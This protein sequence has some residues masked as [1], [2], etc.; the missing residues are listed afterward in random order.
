M[1]PKSRFASA[2][3]PVPVPANPVKKATI[4]SLHKLIK[5]S[6]LRGAVSYEEHEKQLKLL[7]DAEANDYIKKHGETPYHLNQYFRKMQPDAKEYPPMPMEKLYDDFMSMK[8]E[9]KPK[10]KPR[11]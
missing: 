4:P 7:R 10:S 6:Q 3:V 2:P 9:I 5:N 11:N 8:K 1:P